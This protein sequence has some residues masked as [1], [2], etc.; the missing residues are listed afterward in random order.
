VARR[1]LSTGLAPALSSGYLAW[2]HSQLLAELIASVVGNTGNF[3]FDTDKPDG[4]P[5]KLLDVSHLKT[6]G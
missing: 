6:L 5:R 1:D 3:T 4:S 2:P